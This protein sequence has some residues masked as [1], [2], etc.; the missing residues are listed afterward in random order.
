MILIIADKMRK[1]DTLFLNIDKVNIETDN[2]LTTKEI[3]KEYNRIK[4]IIE[5]GVCR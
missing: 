2:K 4:E 5:N 1:D 3:I